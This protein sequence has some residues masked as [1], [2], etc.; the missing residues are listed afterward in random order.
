VSFISI[1]AEVCGIYSTLRTE[2]LS[3]TF[4]IELLGFI[5]LLVVGIVRYI[6]IVSGLY[7]GY[8]KKE[9]EKKLEMKTEFKI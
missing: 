1:F 7:T 4:I 3:F 9:R 5:F 6:V 8:A 2:V